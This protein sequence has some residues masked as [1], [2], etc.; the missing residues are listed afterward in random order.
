MNAQAHRLHELYKKQSTIKSEI[1]FLKDHSKM[2]V[3]MGNLEDAERNSYEIE[4]LE[5]LLGVVNAQILCVRG[6]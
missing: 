1:S 3:Q 5:D 2:L 4:G 6:Y